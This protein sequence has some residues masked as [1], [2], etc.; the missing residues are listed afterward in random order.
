M[1]K[2]TGPKRAATGGVGGNS[3]AASQP[4]VEKY[5]PQTVDEVAHQDEVVSA[6]KTALHDGNLPH[7][8]FYGPPGSGKTSTIL[9]VCKQL[10]GAAFRE[11]VLELNASDER[12]IS[13]VREKVKTFAKGATSA[14]TVAGV[15]CPPWKVIILDEADS[16]TSDAQSALRRTMETYSKV[17]RFCLVCNYVSRIIEPLASRCAK[18]RFRPLDGQV[19]RARLEYVAREEGLASANLGPVLQCVM[20]VSNG[21]LRKAITYLQ[22]TH[23]FY[24]NDLVPAHIVQIAGLIPEET[25][26][27]FFASLRSNSFQQ[28]E[29]AVRTV[30]LDGHSAQ[31]LLEQVFGRLLVDPGITD[32]QKSAILIKIADADRNLN[33]GCDEY[34]Q[35]LSV[36]SLMMQT[37]CV[38]Q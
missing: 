25:V 29:T 12:G 10:F 21:D 7:L 32:V 31:Q 8:L 17:T 35:L 15:P 18:F 3:A 27:A 22:S 23:T 5:R 6:L 36:A 9:A 1:F 33:D 11:R 13:V 26:A 38:Q 30:L 19:M 28:L 24:G 16:M 14:H 2:A 20:D 34:L 37:F 4:W